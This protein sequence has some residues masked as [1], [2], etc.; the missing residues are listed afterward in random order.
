MRGALRSRRNQIEVT[1]HSTSRT[2]AADIALASKK[3]DSQIPAAMKDL[4]DNLLP[5]LEEVAAK[6]N[7][8]VMVGCKPDA[9]SG[10]IVAAMLV[11]DATG[12][13]EATVKTLKK[14]GEHAWLVPHNSAYT[15]IPADSAVIIGKVVSVLRRLL[16]SRHGTRRHRTS[17]LSGCN[18]RPAERCPA[19]VPP[20]AVLRR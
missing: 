16:A 2:W 18:R 7:R 9:D 8:A 15:P 14:S 3:F 1:E 10:D 12:D 13:Y 17:S 5:R 4:E 11:S 6:V 20:H 19:P